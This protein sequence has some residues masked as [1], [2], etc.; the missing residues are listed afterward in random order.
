KFTIWKD[1]KYI[2][3]FGKKVSKKM[4]KILLEKG[5]VGFRNLKSRK[6]NVF[7]EYFRYEK[8][9]GTEYYNWKIEF[10]D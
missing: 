1:D 10:I 5:R 8:K 6:G 7:S 4:V 2:Q 3:S 9:E